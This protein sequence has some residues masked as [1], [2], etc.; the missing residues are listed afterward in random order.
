[1]QKH[2]ELELVTAQ[3][4]EDVDIETIR[5]IKEGAAPYHAA[6]QAVK[7]VTDR[8]RAESAVKSGG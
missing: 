8:R 5:L 4:Q 7:V 6:Q 2:L 1:M 3:W